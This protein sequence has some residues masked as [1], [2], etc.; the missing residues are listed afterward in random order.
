MSYAVPRCLHMVAEIGVAD[1]LD[2]S[3][4]TAA[5]LASATG[6]NPAAL[7]RVLRLLSAYGVFEQRND[8]F[9][10]T[11]ASRL[12]RSD[13]PQSM[14]SYVRMIGLPVYWESFEKMMHTMKTGTSTTEQITPGGSWAYMAQNP[15]ASKLFDEAMTGKAHGQVA[16]ILANYDF[17]GFKTI[18]DI[19]GGRGHLLQAILNAAPQTTGVL[20]DQ[21]HVVK[22]LAPRP[23]FNLQ[24]GDFFKD[25]L[26]VCDAYLIMQVIHDWSDEEA[27]QILSAVRRSAPSHAKLLLIEALVPEH[28]DPSWIKIL[29]IFMM[30]LLTGRERTRNEFDKLLRHT[31]FHL[32]RVIEIGLGTS[33]LE[34][35]VI[36]V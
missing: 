17:T 28:T 27:V 3:P 2:E 20:F 19:G 30:V 34:S 36:P 26:P 1:A 4:G 12:L 22:D 11:P 15:E 31:G 29:D 18:A 23:R 9:V 25:A 7:A 8:R 13:H 10:H 35:S 16:G 33:I 6:M 21:P 14:R 5:E 24:G 32:D